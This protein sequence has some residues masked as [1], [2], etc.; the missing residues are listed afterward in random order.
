MSESFPRFASVCHFPTL[1]WSL[2]TFRLQSPVG[3]RQSISFILQNFFDILFLLA[4]LKQYTSMKMFS[5]LVQR[6]R[7]YL[8]DSMIHS[9]NL[10]DTLYASPHYLRVWY[11]ILKISCL[12]LRHGGSNRTAYFMVRPSLCIL[13]FPIPCHQ[14]HFTNILR[15]VCLLLVNLVTVHSR[16]LRHTLMYWTCDSL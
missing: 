14:M 5:C 4:T 8:E 16:L 15:A 13:A 9:T 10:S 1:V 12:Y 7:P 3:Q 11:F 2:L 6:F